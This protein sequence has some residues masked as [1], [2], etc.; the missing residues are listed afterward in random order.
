MPSTG[1]SCSFGPLRGRGVGSYVIWFLV[2]SNQFPTIVNASSIITIVTHQLIVI[3]GDREFVLQ[4]SAP[5]GPRSAAS[6]GVS[7]SPMRVS[8]CP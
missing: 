6:S 4:A 1:R 8:Q 2:L 3:G 7:R 5:V